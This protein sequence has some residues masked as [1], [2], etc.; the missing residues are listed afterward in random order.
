M[1]NFHPG[2]VNLDM[3]RAVKDGANLHRYSSPG[4]G[5]ITLYNNVRY[6][7]TKDL[8]AGTDYL[9]IDAII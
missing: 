5:A 9:G 4:A 6:M 7:L 8:P 1:S 2:L 3:R